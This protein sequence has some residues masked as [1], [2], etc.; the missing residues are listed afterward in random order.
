MIRLLAAPLA[1]LLLTDQAFAG[2][3]WELEKD[4]DAPSYAFAEPTTTDLNIDTVVLSCE[5]G[6]DRRGLQLRLF[7]TDAGPLSPRGKVALRD[8]PIVEIAIDGVRHPAELF[9]ADNSVLVAD[10]ADGPVPM[11]S[12]RLIDALQRGKK[13]ELRFG[14]AQESRG[15]APVF[16]SSAIVDLQTGRGGAA[17]A[18]VR[19]C[20]DGKAPEVAQS[21]LPTH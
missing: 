10:S 19:R 2:T 4:V 20:A 18:T 16:D 21:P 3:G 1:L 15:Q 9:F 7:L 11:L 5:Q 14:L 6:A 8:D 13:L 17:V 12:K